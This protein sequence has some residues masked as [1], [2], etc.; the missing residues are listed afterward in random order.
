MVIGGVILLP[1]AMREVGGVG[2]FIAQTPPE[3]FTFWKAGTD[4]IN[5]QDLVMFTLTGFPFWCT[6][7]YLLQRTFAARSVKD[8]S[9]G[10]A[11]AAILTGPLTLCYILPGMCGRIIYSGENALANNDQILPMLFKDVIPQGLGGL[12]I[13]ALIAAAGTTPGSVAA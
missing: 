8:A 5:W 1:L 2:S 12:F 3:L 4:G 11:L 13:A 9:T 7:Q 6:S 10:L